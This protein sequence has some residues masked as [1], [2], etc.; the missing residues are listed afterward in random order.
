M[1][2]HNKQ[3]RAN[4]KSRK[5]FSLALLWASFALLW[6]YFALLAPA[7]GAELSLNERSI[8]FEPPAGYCILSDQEPKDLAAI[9]SLRQ[10]QKPDGNILW[11]FADCNELALLRTGHSSML[12]HYGQ[13]MAVHPNGVFQPTPG[14]S[15]FEFTQHIGR[16]IP[17]L[18]ITRVARTAYGRSA[19][20][21]APNQRLLHFGLTTV[22]AAAAYAGLLVENNWGSARSLTAGVMALTLVKDMPIAVVLYG[23]YAELADYRVLRNALRPIVGVFIARNEVDA[24]AA[25]HSNVE[26]A[27]WEIWLHE[28]SLINWSGA[29]FA[30]FLSLGFATVILIAARRFRS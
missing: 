18:D 20:P 22:D 5:L 2:T 6:A 30:G 14:M 24:G 29:M 25:R 26:S 21:N 23:P 7:I 8:T 12:N 13:A 27:A 16:N 9:E 1:G 3:W 4:K 28:L 10:I 15:R 19:A 17:V 11:M